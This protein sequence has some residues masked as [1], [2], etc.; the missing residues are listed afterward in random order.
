MALCDTI[1]CPFDFRFLGRVRD[2]DVNVIGEEL[3]GR[4]AFRHVYHFRADDDFGF[5][6]DHALRGCHHL[7]SNGAKFSG[8]QGSLM[9]ANECGE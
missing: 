7:V 1:E 2:R 9:A 3:R 6:T 8:R 5:L 4:F